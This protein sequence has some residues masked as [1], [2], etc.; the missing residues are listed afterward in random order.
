MTHEFWGFLI[1]LL[2][3]KNHFQ[4]MWAPEIFPL[5]F[6]LSLVLGCF[7]T[8][9]YWSDLSWRLKKDFLQ[10]S[11]SS[12]WP[13]NSSH[14]GTLSSS[15]LRR[16]LGSAWVPLA[17]NVAWNSFGQLGETILGLVS[18]AHCP[19]FS[20]IQYLENWCFMYFILGFSQLF[21]ARI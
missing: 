6:Y 5:I 2:K 10:P 3:T 15:Q 14:L 16:L 13:V 9:L 4:P 11:I 17:C 20:D 7:F 1:W 19:S 8:C 21:Q 18:K 12:L